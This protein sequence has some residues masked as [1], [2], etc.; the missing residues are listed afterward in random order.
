VEEI[1]W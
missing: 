1:K